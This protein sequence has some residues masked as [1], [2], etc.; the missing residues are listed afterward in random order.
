MESIYIF[1]SFKKGTKFKNQF[2]VLQCNKYLYFVNNCETKC[3]VVA[4]IF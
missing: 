1:M 4:Y 2:I 3:A